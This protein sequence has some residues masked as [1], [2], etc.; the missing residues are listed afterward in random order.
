MHYED[1][2]PSADIWIVFVEVPSTTDETA[3]RIH[4]AKELV[5]KCGVS[6]PN[7]FSHEVVFEWAIPEKYVLHKVS[8]RALME[9]GLQEHYFI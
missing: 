5:E 8:L 3:T 1:G 9:R 4:S 2:E 7:K 6:D